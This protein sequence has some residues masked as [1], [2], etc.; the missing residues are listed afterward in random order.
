MKKKINRYYRQ[1]R[2]KLRT[3]TA[4][5]AAFLLTFHISGAVYP[6]AAEGNRARF[7]V[8]DFSAED[9][10]L[11]Q[12]TGDGTAFDSG[13]LTLD[14]KLMEEYLYDSTQA[15]S[16]SVS[17]LENGQELTDEEFFPETG[18]DQSEEEISEVLAET[19]QEQIEEDPSAE[20]EQWQTE[21][22]APA[23]T[24]QEQTEEEASAETEQELT[25]EEAPAETDQEQTEEEPSAETDQELTEQE[26]SAETEQE[27][28]E[29][30]ALPETEQ[31]LTEQEV[32]AET[33]QQTEEEENAQ[34]LPDSLNEEAAEDLST[35]QSEEQNPSGAVPADPASEQLQPESPNSEENIEEIVEETI[36]VTIEEAGEE[37][38]VIPIENGSAGTDNDEVFSGYVTREL[39]LDQDFNGG[40]IEDSQDV[41]TVSTPA[42]RSNFSS[43]RLTGYN[44]ILYGQLLQKIRQVAAGEISNT[45][46]ELSLREME[47]EG[48]SWSAQ[49]LGVEVIVATN[50]EGKKYITDEAKAA[51]KSLLAI[52][53][54][55]VN[56][57]LL[58]DCPYDLYWY[59]KTAKSTAT[60]FGF[61]AYTS[62][63][64]WRLKLSSQYPYTVRMPVSANYSADGSA[65]TYEVNTQIGTSVSQA[66]FNAR[67]IVEQYE[68]CT[69]YEKLDAYRQEICSRTSYNYAAIN[70]GYSYGDPWQLI[71]ALDDDTSNKVVC[72]GYSKAF[73]YLCDLSSFHDIF[74]ECISVSG[75]LCDPAVV[76]EAVSSNNLD[77]LK[78][79][80]HMWNIVTLRDGRNY[81][82]DV[83]NCD[84]NTVGS[85]NGGRNLFLVGTGDQD[86]SGVYCT[87][88]VTYGYKFNLS[89]SGPGYVYDENAFLRF[90]EE[91]LTLSEGRVTSETT[92]EGAYTGTHSH[93]FLHVDEETSTCAQRGHSAGGQCAICGEYD[94]DV[95]WYEL[96]DHTPGTWTVTAAPTYEQEG[97]ETCQCT[98][99]GAQMSGT[100]PMLV[101]VSGLNLDTEQISLKVCGSR[102]LSAT[103]LPENAADKAVSWY[104]SDQKVAR[105][106]QNG[107]VTAVSPGTAEISAVT[108]DLNITAS[109]TVTVEALDLEN[110]EVTLEI[111]QQ[112]YTYDGTE[113]KPGV[114]VRS[115]DREFLRN[116]DYTVEYTGNVNAG[117]NTARVLVTGLEKGCCAGSSVLTFTI[118]KAEQV[119]TAS[120]VSMTMFSSASVIVSGAKGTLS[121]TSSDSSV[122]KVG[123][124]DG[125]LTGVSPG[126]ARVTVKAAAK[127]SYK[128]G[129]TVITV[130]VK[131]YSLLTA[132]TVITVSSAEQVYDG[133]AKTPAVTV[134]DKYGKTLK[135]GTDYTLIY[136]SNINAGTN[137]GKVS[138]TGTGSYSGTTVKTFTI[139][140]A[141]QPLSIKV[142]SAKAAVGKTVTVTVTGAKGKKT[143]SSSAPTV[144]AVSDTGVVTAKKVGTTTIKAEA[145]ETANYLKT[146]KTIKINVVPAATTSLLI[147]NQQT[148]F[149]LSWKKV[150]GATG[151]DIYRGSVKIKTISGG[152]VVTYYDK[153]TLTNGG[154][155]VYRI[156]AR[157]STGVSTLSR[158]A[159]AFRLTRPS[160]TSVKN[161][162]AGQMTVTWAL[163]S[164]ATGYQIQY[165]LSS[166]FGIVR[167]VTVNGAS[168]LKRVIKSLTRGGIWYVRIRSFK[169][170]DNHKYYSMW[171]PVRKIT[172]TR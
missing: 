90:G 154:K 141:A 149:K 30:E 116:T 7:Y 22:E 158:S 112:G 61:S 52:S 54:T 65:G 113:K 167:S 125:S 139:K 107:T 95:I 84:G 104:S 49:D 69:D 31:E 115:G 159:T 163:N 147:Y 124:Q 74:K 62:G 4:F 146:T 100:I 27:Q 89:S 26:A 102:T 169:T 81:L 136:S 148:G 77:S 157:A 38:S 87:G 25:E 106:D 150:T 75:Y 72:E 13:D 10:G 85:G 119:I 165:S 28:T 161:T 58:A 132:G 34:E 12:N 43:S 15:E 2:T 53:Y 160:I 36:E 156:Y 20:V 66:F 11:L 79:K 29:E 129:Q 103:V 16:D 59:D 168:T 55:S 109:C 144:A 118:G 166:D 17:A 145:A 155:Y 99:C 96:A 101:H 64:V 88:N 142:S 97:T 135:K 172:I 21:E 50:A 93:I 128:A 91:M 76:A 134:R 117:E 48:Q 47:L 111:P 5:A 67:S 45:V 130:T 131:A 8:S 70:N 120:N 133:K 82:V 14:E 41:E 123:A 92:A 137:T 23:E 71:Y 56:K 83:T 80:S 32:S 140:K 121:Y 33:E 162:G 126:T 73:Q 63:G 60:T 1:Y 57:A 153:S 6:L 35:E 40:F 68:D 46:F 127:G 164:R 114:R 143:Y 78:N 152:S 51:A 105:V 42:L 18:L 122:V 39:G 37:E 9:A 86:S 44:R 138:I 94:E 3:L 19:D 151:Y 110:C 98:V 108:N 24:D 170:V 171:S